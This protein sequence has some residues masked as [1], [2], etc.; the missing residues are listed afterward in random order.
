[1]RSML[2]SMLVF[3]IILV[4]A[5]TS[6]VHA[7]GCSAKCK[8]GECQ[9]TDC[10]SNAVCKCNWMGNPICKCSQKGSL[11]EIGDIIDDILKH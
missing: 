1:M 8:H 7:A 11:E 5:A 9:I 10:E 6:V 4:F 2:S 3:S